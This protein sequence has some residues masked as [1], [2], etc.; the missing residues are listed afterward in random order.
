MDGFLSKLQSKLHQAKI[1]NVNHEL[2]KV[3]Q[4]FFSES[5]SYLNTLR[6]DC[7]TVGKL[8]RSESTKF[9]ALWGSGGQQSQVEEDH[10]VSGRLPSSTSL[11]A[12]TCVNSSKYQY[13][14]T[15]HGLEEEE[16]EDDY[17]CAVI[18]EPAET[19]LDK[20]IR[21]V[22]S[23]DDV[24]VPNRIQAR[25]RTRDD[26]RKQLVA[27][28]SGEE[29]PKKNQPY[30]KGF[31]SKLDKDLQI[32]FINDLVEQEDEDEESD[33]LAYPNSLEGEDGVLD[34]DSC[35]ALQ[36]TP[37]QITRSKLLACQKPARRLVS[38]RER[39][40][41]QREKELGHVL[42]TGSATDPSR[43]RLQGLN[44]TAIQIITNHYHN[45]IEFLNNELVK[46]LMEKDELQIEQDSQL[47][48]IQDLSA[49]RWSQH[50]SPY[51][52]IPP[53]WPG[54]GHFLG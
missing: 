19:A 35:P 38:V 29:A 10:Q 7:S 12:F 3:K 44:L 13:K 17:G 43:E 33:S 36:A 52:T 1:S 54:K 25:P 48:D 28:L 40:R 24:A 45:Q 53:E 50:E 8:I 31:K 41:A 11:P 30:N 18:S 47:L 21:V 5:S 4:S 46:L 39:L 34:R 16:E 6:T 9:S 27:G 51:Q 42:G 14:S 32:C 23:K 2:G 37:D 49:S 15:F 20:F 26:V 22:E